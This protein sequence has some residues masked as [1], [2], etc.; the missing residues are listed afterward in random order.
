MN[1]G[2][3]YEFEPVTINVP[4]IIIDELRE[5]AKCIKTT[6]DECGDDS[7]GNLAIA[8]T[9]ISIAIKLLGHKNG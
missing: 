7:V 3:Q 4:G 1:S 8:I 2:I 9:K 5:A 6:I